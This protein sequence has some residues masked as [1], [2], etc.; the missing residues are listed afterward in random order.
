MDQRDDDDA[1]AFREAVR[2]TRPL[3]H[4]VRISE[5][6]R[7]APRARFRR[8]DQA[9]VLEE[10]LRLSAAEL[11]VESGEEL[12]FRRAG[13]QDTVLRKLRRGHYRVEAEL[14]LHGLSVDEAREALRLFLADAVARHR[15]CVRIVHGKGRGSGPRGPVLKKAVNLILRK[16]APVV[17]FCSARQIDGGTGAIYALLSTAPATCR[18]SLAATGAERGSRR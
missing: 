4:P 16:T 9:A 5:R 3:R 6:P 13:V 12:S 1:R 15:R 8:A 17:A 18:P 7:P 2:G 10:S 14:D 11:D